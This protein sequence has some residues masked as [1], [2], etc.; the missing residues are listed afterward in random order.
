MS[1]DETIEESEDPFESGLIE[2]CVK[3]G[4]LE[5]FTEPDGKTT[6]EYTPHGEMMME[7]LTIGQMYFDG[8]DEGWELFQELVTNKCAQDLENI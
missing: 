2:K 4:Q 7:L 6:F 3:L 8:D 1:F 5:P